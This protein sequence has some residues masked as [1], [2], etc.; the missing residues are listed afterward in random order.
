MAADR[1]SAPEAG[2]NYRTPASEGATV[3]DAMRPGVVSCPPDTPLRSVAQMM[4]MQ[5]IHCVVVKDLA[6]SGWG[7]VSDVDVLR[8]SGERLDE[9]TAGS[10]AST[11]LLTVAPDETLERAA[12]MMVE[13]EATHLM[14]V[15]SSSRLPLGILSSI[16]VAGVIARGEA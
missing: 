15:G 14:V 7:I 3:S 4:A 10:I 6:R 2:G 1:P 11:E 9:E 5:H 13:L 12:Q 16:D 8:A